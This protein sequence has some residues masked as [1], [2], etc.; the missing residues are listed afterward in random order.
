MPQ[1]YQRPYPPEFRRDALR[2]LRLAPFWCP[3]TCRLH[4]PAPHSPTS[5]TSLLKLTQTAGPSPLAA[6][7][8]VP[9][10]RSARLARNLRRQAESST[11]YRNYL[12]LISG[13]SRWQACRSQLGTLGR[14]DLVR[15]ARLGA[16]H[17]HDGVVRQRDGRPDRFHVEGAHKGACRCVNVLT[18]HPKTRVSSVDEVQLLMLLVGGIRVVVLADEAIAGIPSG[19]GVDTERGDPEVIADRP[20]LRICVSDVGGWDVGQRGVRSGH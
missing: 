2:L 9:H 7:V 12:R 16:D 8:T 18:V 3:C 19:V 13:R 6:H 20:P 14:C 15:S 17:E 11:S 1:R 4:H 10:W 5:L